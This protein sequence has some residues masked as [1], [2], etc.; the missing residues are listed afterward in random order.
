MWSIRMA[1]RTLRALG[2]QPV[3][4]AHAH[5]TI[6][7][8]TRCLGAQVPLYAAPSTTTTNTDGD[9]ELSTPP[10][11]V[12][13]VMAEKFV[14]LFFKKNRRRF[15]ATDNWHPSVS[16]TLGKVWGLLERGKFAEAASWLDK[17]GGASV[18]DWKIMMDYI[19]RHAQDTHV[20]GGD[21]LETHVAVQ[22]RPD[23]AMTLLNTLN[24]VAIPE[25]AAFYGLEVLMDLDPVV[26]RQYLSH[27][28]WS[29]QLSPQGA[30]VAVEVV[31][32]Q[33]AA[34]A[35]ALRDMWQ[36][37][38]VFDVRDGPTP[39]QVDGKLLQTIE[40]QQA[41]ADKIV[42]GSESSKQS[43][44]QHF[45]ALADSEEPQAPA[46][47]ATTQEPI[48]SELLALSEDSEKKELISAYFVHLY[49]ILDGTL[50]TLTL[51]A[52]QHSRDTD[53]TFAGTQV[54]SSKGPAASVV[55]TDDGDQG[56]AG[57][58]VE[59]ASTDDTGVV[60]PAKRNVEDLFL[61]QYDTFDMQDLEL[62]KFEREVG[63]ISADEDSQLLASFA[64]QA[65][66]SNDVTHLR[67]ECDKAA[68][69]IDRTPD[70]T[71]ESLFQQE[72]HTRLLDLAVAMAEY[73]GELPQH[74]KEKEQY[75]KELRESINA[76]LEADGGDTAAHYVDLA[77]LRPPSLEL[78]EEVLVKIEQHAQDEV[79][80]T[81]RLRGSVANQRTQW[82]MDMVAYASQTSDPDATLLELEATYMSKA[83][84]NLSSFATI[85][86]TA[87]ALGV[88]P[89][90]VAQL[91]NMHT[92]LVVYNLSQGNPYRNIT[93]GMAGRGAY[94]KER[95]GFDLADLSDSIHMHVALDD[96]TET[97]LK[98]MDA[99]NITPKNVAESF[100]W[101]LT[102][103]AE[104]L[105]QLAGQSKQQQLPL[106][107][108]LGEQML[109]PL[110][111]QVSARRL[112][113]MSARISEANTRLTEM[114]QRHFPL[115]VVSASESVFT[116]AGQIRSFLQSASSASKQHRAEALAFV[117]TAHALRNGDKVKVTADGKP[118]SAFSSVGKLAAAAQSVPALLLD[119]AF[120]RLQALC[121]QD[122]VLTE[123][124]YGLELSQLADTV[125]AGAG[126]SDE[127][128]NAL[129]SVLNLAV[130]EVQ[131]KH[132]KATGSAQQAAAMQ[133]RFLASH[134]DVMQQ[135]VAAT[136]GKETGSAD[137]SLA[138]VLKPIAQAADVRKALFEAA[139]KMPELDIVLGEHTTSTP[140]V[141]RVNSLM[142]GL[143]EVSRAIADSSVT[144]DAFAAI[145][146]DQLS[147]RQQAASISA[148][149]ALSDMS[150]LLPLDSS[151]ADL[152]AYMLNVFA[153][154]L[155]EDTAEGRCVRTDTA[156]YAVAPDAPLTHF[157]V[158]GE[159]VGPRS[160]R[161]RVN[162][163]KF[164]DLEKRP[165]YTAAGTSTEP[166]V[167]RAQ[168]ISHAPPAPLLPLDSLRSTIAAFQGQAQCQHAMNMESFEHVQ[169]AA[170]AH[171]QAYLEFCVEKGLLSQDHLESAERVV[172]RLNQLS[173]D[174]SLATQLSATEEMSELFPLVDLGE[175]YDEFAASIGLQSGG[176]K[177]GVELSREADPICLGATLQGRTKFSQNLFDADTN[178]WLYACNSG[179]LQRDLE[180]R[181]L[182]QTLGIKYVA[183]GMQL[184]KAQASMDA[185]TVKSKAEVSFLSSLM[186][187]IGL[188]RQAQVPI[189]TNHIRWL[190]QIFKERCDLREMMA[191]LKAADNNNL[192]M[193]TSL[194][195]TAVS[196]LDKLVAS[197][198]VDRT[199]A[200]SVVQTLG[201]TYLTSPAS[202]SQ[203]IASGSTTEFVQLVSDM[204]PAFMKSADSARLLKNLFQTVQT[205]EAGITS[206]ELSQKLLK[207]FSTD[208]RVTHVLEHVA[209]E[210]LVEVVNGPHTTGPLVVLE[211]L[212]QSV[213]NHD[214]ENALNA[215]R[216]VSEAQAPIDGPTKAAALKMFQD[217]AAAYVVTFL[218]EACTFSLNAM[219]CTFN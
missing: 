24:T 184:Y 110:F 103:L 152:E 160:G 132:A 3:F 159:Y 30:S 83:L 169:G 33:L 219:F 192:P 139:A 194:L 17:N 52:N 171:V 189:D 175:H 153:Q 58:T 118:L 67:R 4:P 148:L 31:L 6:V 77:E 114:L 216:L 28:V 119:P 66:A 98:R 137:K 68:Q 155:G 218:H 85:I 72:R 82:E 88:Q 142:A 105:S 177:R 34:A 199:V 92:A 136:S 22:S 130:S 74:A 93:H 62:L 96:W 125:V 65:L 214:E 186:G 20:K 141:Q 203:L 172:A 178:L 11:A 106:A 179:V 210:D 35:P 61:G 86:D 55:A 151:A 57:E 21:D 158:Q 164:S 202:V 181:M 102:K 166:S 190:T 43:L 154:G 32:A 47:C 117:A 180:D 162:I 193:T 23:T 156:A 99:A 188:M 95:F 37:M 146:K 212:R 8:Q 84:A 200:Q 73:R 41:L 205:G 60:A 18:D 49:D 123:Q 215:L 2:R 217:T 149:A 26:G 36:E 48:H 147:S 45:N 1:S 112:T 145:L 19:V 87:I 80:R 128:A 206:S 90:R 54:G 211:Y 69:A 94:F 71:V 9:K 97:A 134:P 133:V 208:P 213:R 27:L 196:G 197:S 29:K 111:E 163:Q 13:D 126:L 150:T 127:Q 173:P 121:S 16:R 50:N 161:D 91:R 40:M 209:Y 10:R 44:T 198:S 185:I 108:F 165:A 157:D 38:V 81:H 138:E 5:R 39:A 15:P 12:L 129:S 191:T 140:F 207:M 116:K 100:K 101:P 131:W 25:R 75:I 115:N 195:S 64:L 63:P 183:G 14:D 59:D 120:V 187:T 70:K 143:P 201:N 56:D 53:V 104:A 109:D 78:D 46:T 167:Y 113:S 7:G 122:T 204:C 89:S 174:A 76:N 182:A 176:V 107:Q 135:V 79:L 124:L 170:G 51:H 144:D 168:G 42:T